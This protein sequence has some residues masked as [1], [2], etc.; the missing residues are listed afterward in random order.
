MLTIYFD[1]FK[2]FSES[3]LD[4]VFDTMT[5]SSFSDGISLREHYNG[6]IFEAI[7]YFV[8]NVPN[9]C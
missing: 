4:Y 7:L 9:V 6:L 2:T 8:Q 3:S 5:F 1:K